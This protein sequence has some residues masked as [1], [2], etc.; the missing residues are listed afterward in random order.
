MVDGVVRHKR[1][2]MLRS[3]CFLPRY[4]RGSELN[5]TQTVNA[6]GDGRLV[7]R[8]RP[9]GPMVSPWES[10]PTPPSANPMLRHWDKEDRPPD[11]IESAFSLKRRLAMSEKLPFRIHF[12]QTSE[13]MRDPLKYE[14]NQLGLCLRAPLV[15][16]TECQ[17]P[18]SPAGVDPNKNIYK[19][20]P[21]V[22]FL[23]EA[24]VWF[25]QPYNSPRPVWR[26]PTSDLLAASSHLHSLESLLLGCGWEAGNVVSQMKYGVV[27]VDDS[28]VDGKSWNEYTMKTLGERHRSLAGTSVMPIWVFDAKLLGFEALEKTEEVEGLAL[29]RFG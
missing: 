9:P 12:R 20:R 7:L 5:G 2:K 26:P 19:L 8:V 28:T 29:W 11:V 23:R 15:H 16:R 10:L 17:P 18:T 24:F 4:G 27:F 13:A 22:K 6:D 14:T 3:P 25:A 21:M 1:M